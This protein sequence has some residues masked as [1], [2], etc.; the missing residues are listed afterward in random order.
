MIPPPSSHH[1][2]MH[3]QLPK[4]W[5]WYLRKLATHQI[6]SHACDQPNLTTSIEQIQNGLIGD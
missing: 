1:K 4:G 5:Y 6:S 3:L 2:S